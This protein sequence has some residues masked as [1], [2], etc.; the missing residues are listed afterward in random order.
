MDKCPKHAYREGK[1]KHIGVSESSADSLR[2]ACS[3]A[4]ITAIQME[5]SPFAT[6]IESST[7]NL[8]AIN[9]STSVK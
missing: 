1:I 9:F 7:T 4:P 8:L 6:E 5:Y 3:I 2:R